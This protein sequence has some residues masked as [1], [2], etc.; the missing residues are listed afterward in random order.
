MCGA[1]L[2]ARRGHCVALKSQRNF[3]SSRGV[4]GVLNYGALGGLAIAEVP[5]PASHFPFRQ[6][7]SRP[8]KYYF[9]SNRSSLTGVNIEDG[10]GENADG[11]LISG[12][13]I[14][15]PDRLTFYLEENLV[16][17]RSLINVGRLLADR[18]AS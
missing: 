16:I 1:H 18:E 13:G 5:L 8:V 3:F 15:L 4:E 17:A 6:A 11:D 2:P 7:G 12:I 14:A 10:S 9:R